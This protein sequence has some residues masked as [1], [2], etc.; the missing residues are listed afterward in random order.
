MDDY[1]IDEIDSLYP[2]LLQAVDPNG[3]VIAEQLA[4]TEDWEW[5]GRKIVQTSPIMFYFTQAG[6]VE[7]VILDYGDGEYTCIDI[8]PPITVTS[9]DQISITLT[10]H[11]NN[12]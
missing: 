9:G 10:V 5:R 2:P 12:E 1:L 8:G 3:E 11:T 7:K 4:S 6:T